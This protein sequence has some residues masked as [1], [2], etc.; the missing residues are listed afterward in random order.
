MRNTE[1]GIA[2]EFNPHNRTVLV[3]NSELL[4]GSVSGSFKSSVRLCTVVFGGL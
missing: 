3:R 4:V 1:L 2:L